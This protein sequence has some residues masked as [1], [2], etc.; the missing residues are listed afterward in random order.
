MVIAVRAHCNP[1]DIIY[2]YIFMTKL[3][4]IYANL[5]A[6]IVYTPMRL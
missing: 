6:L 3:H 5:K 4:L 2:I 1:L